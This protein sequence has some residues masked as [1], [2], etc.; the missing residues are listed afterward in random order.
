[1]FFNYIFF[2]QNLDMRKFL[3]IVINNILVLFYD[4]LTF[5]HYGNENLV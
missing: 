5:L 1:M 4:V 2:N 3:T